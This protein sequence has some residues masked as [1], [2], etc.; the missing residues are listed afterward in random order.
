MLPSLPSLPAPVPDSGIGPRAASEL[1]ARGISAPRGAS[2]THPENTLAAF[3]EAVRLG[4]HQI[5]FDVRATSDSQLVVIHDA[6]V[7][8]T[9]DGRG[10]VDRLTLEQIRRLDAGSWKGSQFRGERVPTLVEVLRTMPRNAW[11]N[12]HVKGKPWLAAEVAMLL[13]EED[14][15]HQSVLAVDEEGAEAAREIHPD[16]W[17]C[18]MDRQLTRD[19]YLDHALRSSADFIQLTS[20]RGLPE[21]EQTRRLRNA[22]LRINYC[23]VEDPTRLGGL[24][25]LGVDFPLVDDVETAVQAT[26]RL[27]IPALAPAFD[28][29]EDR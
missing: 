10:R 15:L 25:A 14:R 28:D 19:A 21:F 23:C 16:L 27:G 22:G 17:I 12:V 11:L 20:L 5:E 24:F 1:P 9:T 4:A 2:A 6:T 7:D 8:R 13:V 3:R 29:L 26:L 18:D